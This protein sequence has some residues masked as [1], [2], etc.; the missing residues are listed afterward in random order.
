MTPGEGSRSHMLQI[1]PSAA[2]LKKQRQWNKAHRR[3]MGLQSSLRHLVL[4]ARTPL[5]QIASKRQ[6]TE[7]K[8]LG[9]G[10]KTTV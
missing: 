10:K 6:V 8:E 3:G 7:K 9:H 2:K 5:L 1:R 4:Q